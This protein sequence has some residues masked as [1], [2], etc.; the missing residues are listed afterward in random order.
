MGG[1]L[2]QYGLHLTDYLG[3][4]ARVGPAGIPFDTTP[5]ALAT[6]DVV[7]VCVKSAATLDAADSIARHVRPGTVVV[8]LQNGVSNADR[9]RERLPGVTVLAGMVP[10]NVLPDG[11][12]RFHQGTEGVLEIE[13]HPAATA[14]TQALDAAR[15][16]ARWHRDMRPV[17][18]AK[19]LLNINNPINA[20]ANIPL[21]QELAQRSFRRCLAL[22]QRE[23]L[24]ILDHAG[25]QPAKLTPVP[26]HWLPRVLD[27]PDAVFRLLAGRMLAIDPLAR[28]SMWEDLSKGR[29]TE[30]D[31]I[32]GEIVSLARLQGVD[33][34]VNARMVALIREAE[35]KGVTTWSGEALWGALSG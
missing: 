5:E 33:A 11:R 8:S 30:I 27:V 18:W 7:L 6:A 1:Q 25:I 12:G 24:Q 26:P 10:F 15:W 3:L 2:A 20:L 28:S 4:D 34:P 19:L 23:A 22:A 32:N 35:T 14:L 16:P 29:T 21:K 13:A 31:W 17:L 9:L